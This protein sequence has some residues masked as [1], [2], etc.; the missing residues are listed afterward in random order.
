M[1][2]QAPRPAP[3]P[4]NA[5]GEDAQQAMVHFGGNA[6]SRQQLAI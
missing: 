4:L 6:G 5:A 2:V 1:H 3:L